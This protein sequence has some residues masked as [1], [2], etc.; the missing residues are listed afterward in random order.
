M[1]LYS[2][3][4]GSWKSKTPASSS[5]PESEEMIE[6]PSVDMVEEGDV[7]VA[8]DQTLPCTDMCDGE[9]NN[10]QPHRGVD[11]SMPGES[12]LAKDCSSAGEDKLGS[13]L[14]DSSLSINHSEGHASHTQ[15][16]QVPGN[17][18]G[19]LP[20]DAKASQ[21]SCDSVGSIAVL[22]KQVSGV[23]SD[24]TFAFGS[25]SCEDVVPDCRVNLKRIP[26]SPG[27]P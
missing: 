3:S 7:T 4:T 12:G 11:F 21:P 6:D 19:Q 8:E 10:D 14:G 24:T 13:D 15:E 1:T 2:S 25:Q 9:R 23:I 16:L 18:E 5:Q 26:C 27:S 22:K 17:I 20:H